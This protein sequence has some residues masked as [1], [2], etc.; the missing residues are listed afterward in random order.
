MPVLR[1]P[2]LDPDNY[3]FAGDQAGR[4][5]QLLE[6]RCRTAEEDH[7]VPER[8]AVAAEHRPVD[9]WSVYHAF[10]VAD[11]PV[12]SD[13]VAVDSA[14]ADSIAEP[15]LAGMADCIC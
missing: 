11:K 14:E 4:H 6:D 10:G 8:T 2:A 9:A 5:A 1:R 12:H 15:E 3:Y 13:S 7:V